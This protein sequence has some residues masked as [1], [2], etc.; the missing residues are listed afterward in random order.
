MRHI[1]DT[2]KFLTIISIFIAI[3]A[4]FEM[5]WIEDK[6]MPK[7]KYDTLIESEHHTKQRLKYLDMTG[8]PR[9]RYDANG[10]GILVQ[11]Q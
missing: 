8:K 7:H 10:R 2:I 3:P 1:S 11:P 9:L 6:P 5:S 4:L